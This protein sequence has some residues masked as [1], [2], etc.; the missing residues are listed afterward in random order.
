M[1]RFV[2]PGMKLYQNPLNWEFLGKNLS[3]M[4]MQG[5]F[6]F[7]LT[8]LVEY[9]FFLKPRKIPVA[10][11]TGPETTED[12]DVALERSKVLGGRVNHALLRM[13]DITK[14]Y[15]AGQHPAVNHLCVAVQP[16]ECFGLLGVNGAGK[17]TTFKMLTGN[18]P[19]TSGDAYIS[20]YSI[21]TEL[22]KAR[23]NIGYCPQFDAIDSLLT[24]WEHLEFYARL[25]GIPEKYIHMVASWGIRK[26]GLKS[27]AHQRA[28]TYSGGNKRKLSTAIALVGNPSIVFLDEPT[29]GMDPKARRFLWNCIIDVVK[30]GH[31]VILTSHSM[32][33]CEALCTRLAIMV[34]G[35]FRC[36]GSIQHLKN[37]YGE[38]YT[39]MLR[40]GN[41]GSPPEVATFMAAAFGQS[42]ILTEQHLNQ[43]EYQLAPTLPLSIIFRR[44]QAAKE[45]L[46]IEDYSV[47][48]TTLD[49]V[50]ISFAKLQADICSEELPCKSLLAHYFKNSNPFVKKA[51]E[52][53]FSATVFPVSPYGHTFGAHLLRLLSP[54]PFSLLQVP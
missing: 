50:F 3:S 44:L 7:V 48:Q 39:L 12:E 22:A 35:Q 18:I 15:R 25:R 19:I 31:A 5:I 37:K 14:I 13:E 32:E 33:E 24:G 54:P 23:Q 17:T 6:Y 46:D 30:E 53:S 52:G 40:V 28:G 42:A 47:S 51:K 45:T 34:N 29:T 8:L 41:M 4:A 1:A 2:G 11:S 10:P 9:K 21:Q 43:M 49:Q 38:G 27:F 26:L 20:G 16:G 36:L